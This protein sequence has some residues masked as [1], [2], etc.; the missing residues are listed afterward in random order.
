MLVTQSSKT[1]MWHRNI[2][3]QSIIPRLTRKFPLDFPFFCFF[4]G[5]FL[6]LTPVLPTVP[7]THSENNSC[8]TTC[9][10]EWGVF[11]AVSPLQKERRVNKNK[12]SILRSHNAALPPIPCSLSLTTSHPL[13][14]SRPSFMFKDYQLIQ[15]VQEHETE[16]KGTILRGEEGMAWLYLFI[17]FHINPLE[18][19]AI[20]PPLFRAC[21]SV[22][23]PLNGRRNFQW[24]ACKSINCKDHYLVSMR[25][26]Q[27]SHSIPPFAYKM[28][29][30]GNQWK[31][32]TVCVAYHMLAGNGFL[33][34]LVK[35]CWCRTIWNMAQAAMTFKDASA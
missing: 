6:S 23:E 30:F 10:S 4:G 7:F 1:A 2:W 13:G 29:Y 11:K 3:I 14:V 27:L 12:T 19:S 8:K 22:L 26:N 15:N 17:G 24:I 18:H 31:C 20:F 33:S 34:H 35:F 28:L 5:F 25:L 16:G 21:V 9:E 32:S